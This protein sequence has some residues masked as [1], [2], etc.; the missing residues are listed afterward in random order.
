MTLFINL[1][2]VNFCFTQEMKV[3]YSNMVDDPEKIG[4][5]FNRHNEGTLEE[6]QKRENTVQKRS[7]RFPC[8]AFSENTISH[9]KY[10][11]YTEIDV[12]FQSSD[13]NVRLA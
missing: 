5:Q 3:L 6:Q 7:Y 9:I 1:K 11:L 4:L 12:L 2:F 13:F 8:A 10:G